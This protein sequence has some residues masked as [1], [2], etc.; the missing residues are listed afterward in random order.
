MEDNNN[1][2]LGT[3]E[4]I[5]EA[6]G[7]VF[8]G[9]GFGYATVREICKRASVNIAAV[10]YHFRDK[11]NLYLSVLKYWRDDAFQKHPLELRMDDD[12]APE[13]YL[14]DFVRSFL[15]RIL[16]EGRPSW[17]WKLVARE[18][19]EPTSAL[20]TMVKETIRPHFEFLAMIVK[21][22]TNDSLDD[23][24]VRLCCLSIISQCIFF[25]YAKPVTERLFEDVTFTT[26]R[27]EVMADHISN[28]CQKAIE[29]L[30]KEGGGTKHETE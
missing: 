30:S 20:E 14:G 9:R 22:L 28:F 16:D 29:S 24:K 27:I 21:R 2:S 10:N 15:F 4:R 19:V 3:R 5:L 1:I 26:E 6:A 23:E 13:K 8:A 11:E 17:F 7:E 18:W 25:V 12:K